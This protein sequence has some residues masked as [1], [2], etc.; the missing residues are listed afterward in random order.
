[1]R[2]SGLQRFALVE[3]YT[4]R[5]T[6]LPRAAVHAFYRSMP[7]RPIDVQDVVTKSLER[8]IDKG[9]LVGYGRRTPRKWFI[10]EVKLTP[11][12]RRLAR[13]L[14]G[15]QLALPL[16]NRRRLKVP[17]TRRSP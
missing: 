6:R 8:L 3:C 12:G 7:R 4:R 10:D 17:G 2:L 5:S 16:T 15:V 9:L 11:A 13:R 14:L 1:M